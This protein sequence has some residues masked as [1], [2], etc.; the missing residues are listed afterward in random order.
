MF[1]LIGSGGSKGSVRGDPPPPPRGQILVKKKWIETI[2]PSELWIHYHLD[3]INIFD[4]KKIK[5][6]LW[7]N[8]N[9]EINF[10]GGWIGPLGAFVSF[11]LIAPF[12][13]S[14]I[15]FW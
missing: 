5:S 1:W 15:R 6:I 7:S 2:Y 14:Q 9:T 13:N 4:E 8:Q 12:E 3:I 10:K 11:P